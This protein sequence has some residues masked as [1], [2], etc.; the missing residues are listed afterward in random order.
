[1]KLTFLIY[2]RRSWAEA[3]KR[4]SV[5]KLLFW[6]ICRQNKQRKKT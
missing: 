5:Y 1:M 6:Y 4:K 3:K 2:C